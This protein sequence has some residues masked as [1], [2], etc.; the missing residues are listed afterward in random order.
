MIVYRPDAEVDYTIVHVGD[1]PPN[2]SLE[3]HTMV[4]IKNVL[5]SNG[6]MRE[7]DEYWVMIVPP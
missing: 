6:L 7:I 3:W 1:E 5:M 4:S 2:V